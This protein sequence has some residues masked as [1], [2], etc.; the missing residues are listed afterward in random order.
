MTGKAI[1]DYYQ[2]E[3]AVCYCCGRNNP[4]GLQIKTY[5]N[6]EE[7]ICYFK[8]KSY[9][10]AFPGIVNGGLIASLIDCYCIVVQPWLR[11]IMLRAVSPVQSLIFFTSPRVSM[12]Y[13]CFRLRLMMNCSFGHVL[14]SFMRR[15][16]L[17]YAFFTPKA[18]SVLRAKSLL[19]ENS[20]RNIKM[21]LL[22]CNM[23]FFADTTIASPL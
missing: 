5:W 2:V 8:P 16:R 22:K 12:P 11:A 6:G 17:S 14:E 4:Y 7:R 20:R 9:H 23:I 21:R 3:K 10:T 19:F 13:I 15:K 1:R 18:K